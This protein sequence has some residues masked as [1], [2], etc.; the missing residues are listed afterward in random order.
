MNGRGLPESNDSLLFSL[1]MLDWFYLFNC[2][3]D[4]ENGIFETSIKLK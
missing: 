1:I 3:S 4:D 2:N